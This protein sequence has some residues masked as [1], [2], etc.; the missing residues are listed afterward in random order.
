[1][2]GDR[3][4]LVFGCGNPGR[5]DDGVGAWLGERIEEL[6]L[7]NT[8]VETPMQLNLEDAAAIAGREAVLFIDADIAARTPYVFRRARAAGHIEFTS[9]TMSPETVLAV[10]AEY[11]SPPPPAWIL[12]IRGFDF[13]F[14]EGLTPDARANAGEALE[15]I[16]GWI[17]SRREVA[18]AESLNEGAAHA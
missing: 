6:G 9:H 8:I 3:T 12:G 1:M 11:F 15:F 7:A 10:C 16:A 18:A 2:N 4:L 5:T 13:G 14:G 17:D